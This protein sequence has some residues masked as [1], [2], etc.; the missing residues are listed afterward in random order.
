MLDIG[1]RKISQV[2]FLYIDLGPIVGEVLKLVL[3]PSMSKM[4]CLMREL[5]YKILI[6]D[7]GILLL[8]I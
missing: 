5:I 6:N 3:V 2:P 4:G 1:M 7:L 8:E